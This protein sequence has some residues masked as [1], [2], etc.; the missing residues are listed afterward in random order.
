[1]K[2]PNAVT[3]CNHCDNTYTEDQLEIGGT[4]GNRY[5]VCPK[6]KTDDALMDME[7]PTHTPDT[8]SAMLRDIAV[9]N[10]AIKKEL[11]EIADYVWSYRTAVNAHEELL[12]ALKETMRACQTW[13]KAY[14]MAEDAIRR[15]EGGK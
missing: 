1:M 9:N 5:P 14:K 12:A 7:T 15:A 8:V 2:T 10:H 4:E 3:R 6:C 13:S 11:H